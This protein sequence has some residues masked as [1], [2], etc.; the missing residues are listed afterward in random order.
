MR[1]DDIRPYGVAVEKT[2]ESNDFIY[3]VGADIIRPSAPA[4]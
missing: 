4:Y 1:T 3:F 2:M